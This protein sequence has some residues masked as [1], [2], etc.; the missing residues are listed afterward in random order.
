MIMPLFHFIEEHT[1]L[2]A[3]ADVAYVTTHAI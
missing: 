3:A 1:A 2:V